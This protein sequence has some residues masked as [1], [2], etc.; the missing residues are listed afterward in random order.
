VARLRL[1]AS[2]LAAALAF[3][4]AVAT[5]ALVAARRE[6]HPRQGPLPAPPDPALG[7]VSFSAGGATLRGWLRTGTNGAAIVLL[8]GSEADRR[9]MLAEDA[10]LASGGFGTL[11][12]D[13]PG[14]GESGGKVTFG[15]PER[16]ALIAA[17]DLLAGRGVRRIGVLGFSV[18]AMVA[19]QVAASDP[20]IGAVAV[21]G[22]MLD[23]AAQARWEARRWGDLSGFAAV[24]GKRLW[25]WDPAAPDPLWAAAALSPR[26]LLV[27]A[28]DSDEVVPP[29]NSL[30]LFGA[31]RDPR[32][33]WVVP[34]AGHGG[35]AAQAGGE[36][37]RRLQAFFAVLL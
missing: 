33:L 37:A 22:A 27:V 13:A 23:V 5:R 28:G 8:H 26:P 29:S 35:Y 12:Y 15:R 18:G 4:A 32:Q 10:A 11:L 24:W 31:A 25:G 30:R 1:L 14:C 7:A 16:E 20:R 17:V 21:E 3:P 6:F 36:Y 34:H 2:L 19:V 9:Q